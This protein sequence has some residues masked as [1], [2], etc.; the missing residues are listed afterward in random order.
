ME[1]IDLREATVE[2]HLHC[3]C[4]PTWCIVRYFLIRKRERLP[5]AIRK[6]Y[7]SGPQSFPFPLL[8]E[9][10]PAIPESCED[11]RKS[12]KQR[13]AKFWLELLIDR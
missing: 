8:V 6:A 12:I 13:S 9:L 5:R 3:R 10:G 7:H 1:L 4:A 2:C 11:L